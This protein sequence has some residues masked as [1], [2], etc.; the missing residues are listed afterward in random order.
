[1]HHS[2]NCCAVC[3]RVL[4]IYLTI[5]SLKLRETEAIAAA[6]AVKAV[7]AAADDSRELFYFSFLKLN[8]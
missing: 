8:V 7:A 1:M 3:A 4:L 5:L 2:L 6:A